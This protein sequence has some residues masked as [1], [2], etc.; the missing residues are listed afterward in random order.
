M[1]R[2]WG[3]STRFEIA[4][5][6][7]ALALLVLAIVASALFAG[8]A[9]ATPGAYRVLLAEPYEEA[10][11][12]LKAQVAAFPEIAAI[13]TVDTGEGTPTAAQL[14]PYDVVVSIGDSS[15]DDPEAWGNSLASYVDGGGV[16]V[17]AGYDSWENP[18]SFPG[19]RFASG[20]YAPFIPGNNG[21]DVTSLGAFD[22]SS[23][24]MEG[25]ST[26]T[27]EDNTEPEPSPGATVVAKWANGKNAIAVKG[28]VV[29]ITA[30]I[31]DDYGS[32]G[33]WSGDYGRVVVNAM[34]ALGRQ[35]LSVVNSNPLGGTVTS[36]AGGINCGATCSSIFAPGTAVSLVATA[37]PGFAFSGFFGSCLGSG[38][39]LV[40]TSAKSVTAG[41]TSFEFGKRVKLDKKK[42]T[43]Q[44]TVSVGGPGALAVSGAKI[45]SRSTVATQPGKVTLPIVAKGKARKALRNRGKAQVGFLLTFTPSGGVAATQ[46]KSVTLKKKLKP[47]PKKSPRK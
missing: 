35:K 17:Q 28:H 38:C 46:A 44:L 37:N 34:R 41:F 18:K 27:T 31:G 13:D 16:V 29:S 14:A 25:V 21:N 45:K 36:S 1:V 30:F 22:A 42:G 39:A 47:K 32:E 6:R 7:V 5:T 3:N 26:L 10:P 8:P 15:Y 24:L 40:M 9:Q 2:S 4:P 12:R 33:I 11:L 20:G 23:P 43:G 19:G